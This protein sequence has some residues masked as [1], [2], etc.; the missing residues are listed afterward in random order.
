ML[1]VIDAGNSNLTL[2]VFRGAELLVQWRLPTKRDQAGAHPGAHLAD[3][4][5]EHLGDLAR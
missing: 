1:L 2:G 4:Q 5:L 3:G